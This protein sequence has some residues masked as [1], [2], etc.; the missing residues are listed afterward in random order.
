MNIE[1]NPLFPIAVFTFSNQPWFQGNLNFSQV[2]N[3]HMWVLKRVW[4]LFSLTILL[5]CHRDVDCL[6]EDFQ[7]SILYLLTRKSYAYRSY[8]LGGAWITWN[9]VSNVYI[10]TKGKKSVNAERNENV[11]LTHTRVF[12]G[13]LC[14]LCVQ[15]TKYNLYWCHGYLLVQ[16][17]Y[18]RPDKTCRLSTKCRLQTAEWVQNADW[19]SKEFFRLLCDNMSSYNLPSVTQSLF[20]FSECVQLSLD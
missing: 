2:N 18:C 20:R 9:I 12:C 19:E 3:T 15:L 1:I 17:A 16:N 6:C 4:I 8:F 13:R 5:S 14:V 7:I 10:L 11:E